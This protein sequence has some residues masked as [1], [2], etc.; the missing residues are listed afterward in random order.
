MSPSVDAERLGGAGARAR[1]RRPGAEQRREVA[2]ARPGGDCHLG[3][4]GASSAS[5]RPLRS[6][7]LTTQGKPA[8]CR[9]ARTA[10]RVCGTPASREPL[11]LAQARAR[12]ARRSRAR[13]GAGGRKRAARRAALRGRRAGRR[14]SPSIALRV[15]EPLERGS[16]SRARIARGER[17]RTPERRGSRSTATR[18]SRARGPPRAAAVGPCPEDE[19]PHRTA[20][21]GQ[22]RSRQNEDV[23]T[24]PW[25]SASRSCEADHEHG[26]QLD[27]PPGGRGA[28]GGGRG[29][30]ELVRGAAGRPSRR[31]GRRARRQPARSRSGRRRGRAR[32]CGGGRETSSSRSSN[33]GSSCARRR[34]RSSTD[35]GARRPRSRSSCASGSRT[36]S[37]S[38]IPLRQPCGKPC[39][40]RRRTA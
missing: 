23:A 21:F 17:A 8:R 6:G 28:R 30:G 35:G 25:A 11:A 3:P 2:V 1:L 19:Q 39:F 31:R 12:R 22:A 29:A 10:Q 5:R 7:G 20:R 38:R 13:S 4:A 16:S 27:G 26:A 36:Q 34:S 24:D 14:R 18:S 15:G 33:C 32:A 37:C 9:R 40:A